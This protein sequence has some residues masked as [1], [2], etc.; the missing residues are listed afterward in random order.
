MVMAVSFPLRRI[1]TDQLPLYSNRSVA[2]KMPGQL[3]GELGRA[4]QRDQVT[5]RNHVDVQAESV[6]R[7]P[8]LEVQREEPVV[9]SRDHPGGYVRPAL[10]GARL[11][12]GDVGLGKVVRLTRGCD[13]RGHI[14]QEVGGQVELGGIPARLGG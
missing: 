12:E 6:P 1:A 13:V 10:D 9:S 14:V 7:D 8:A 4:G 2:S 11:A 5:A 3:I